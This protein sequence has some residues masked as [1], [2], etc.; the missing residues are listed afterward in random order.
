M[1][2]NGGSFALIP[3]LCITISDPILTTT[4]VLISRL[5]H[6]S[7][8][9]RRF[10]RGIFDC[11]VFNLQL[12]FLLPFKTMSEQLQARLES[13]K[14]QNIYDLRGVVAVITGGG[15]VRRS[16]INIPDSRPKII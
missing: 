10:I 5:G 6:L 9:I 12:S 16:H 7:Q 4:T 3:I 13:F 15:S 11:G 8:S 2:E 1:D 14:A